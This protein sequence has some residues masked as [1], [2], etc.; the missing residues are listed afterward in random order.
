M[1]RFKMPHHWIQSIPGRGHRRLINPHLQRRISRD[2]GFTHDPI[3]KAKLMDT[4]V[5]LSDTQDLKST[6]LEVASRDHAEHM[7]TQKVL[8][9]IPFR[10]NLSEITF[11]ALSIAY[12]A[13]VLTWISLSNFPQLQDYP[14]WVYQGYLLSLKFKG[15]PEIS[16]TIGIIPYPV[17][18]STAQVAIAALCLLMSPV[19]ASKLLIYI[20]ILL[21]SFTAYVVGKEQAGRSELA[22]ALIFLFALNGT[23]WNGYI[24]YQFA[25]CALVLYVVLTDRRPDRGVAFHLFWSITIFFTQFMVF[26]IFLIYFG[27]RY[28]LDFSQHSTAGVIRAS[29]RRMTRWPVPLLL[30]SLALSAWYI[31]GR[32]IYP[33]D[34]AVP[35][36]DGKQLSPGL[37]AHVLYKIY[38]MLKI[39]PFQI[40]ELPDGQ[41]LQPSSHYFYFVGFAINACFAMSIIMYFLKF[42]HTS[43]ASFRLSGYSG[44]HVPLAVMTAIISLLFAIAPQEFFGGGNIGER[45]LIPM[46]AVMFALY[47][48]PRPVA[49][50]LAC[51][52]ALCVP[53]YLAFFASFSASGTQP[54]AGWHAQLFT[55][56]PYQFSRHTAFILNPNLDDLPELGFHTSL[57]WT[58]NDPLHRD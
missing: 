38:T 7:M 25:V 19:L 45:L 18:N 50:S 28:I 52:S 13:T 56:R 10:G 42:V 4:P 6:T 16:N 20:Y 21:G 54:G 14:D 41:V 53:I 15:I 37:L 33:Q 29:F 5:N 48:P 57:I 30:P 32:L 58:I 46:I 3:L 40:F 22:F 31:I 44:R 12:V 36:L 55:H 47:P 35:A 17:P 43:V 27:C 23:F 1:W 9:R 11:F 24:N 51:L 2:V 39:G 8:V 34:I 26:W 49:M